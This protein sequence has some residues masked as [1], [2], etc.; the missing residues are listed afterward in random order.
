MQALREHHAKAS[1]FVSSDF[2]SWPLN[3]TFIRGAYAEG[4][5]IGPQLTI[6]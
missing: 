5:F 2:V 6:G 3:A 1:F 4:H